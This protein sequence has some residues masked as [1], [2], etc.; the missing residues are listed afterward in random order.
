MHACWM[1]GN[2]PETAT[3]F[4]FFFFF[5]FFKRVVD[6]LIIEKK[7]AF[8]KHDFSKSGTIDFIDDF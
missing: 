5:F 3:F 6:G 8:L 2:L 1:T 7:T 4:F